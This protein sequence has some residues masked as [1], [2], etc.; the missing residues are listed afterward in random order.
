LHSEQP[1][2]YVLL[3]DLAMINMKLG[4]KGAAMTLAE[5]AVSAN[6][7]EKDAVTGPAPT[8][9]LARVLAGVGE[10]KRAITIL[11]QL[12]FIPYAGPMATQDLPL[13]PALL[14]LDPMF[15]PLRNEPG[16]EK[17]VAPSASK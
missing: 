11:Q 6:P 14:Q 7:V 4:D 17:L 2:N 15:D 16:F 1:G 9:I 8:E 10:S 3:G 13:T 5:Q 12:L